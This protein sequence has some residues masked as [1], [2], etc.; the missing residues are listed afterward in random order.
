M[1]DF[2]EY[3]KYQHRHASTTI[4]GTESAVRRFLRWAP[5][6]GV[7]TEDTSHKEIMKYTRYLADAGNNQHSIYSNLNALSHYF[8]YQIFLG[9]G[10]INPIKAIKIQG[11]KRETLYDILSPEEL[12]E[13]YRSYPSETP[14]DTR[15][16]VIIGLYVF[17]GIHTGELNKIEVHHVDLQRLKILIPSSRRSKSRILNLDPEQL[18]D[19]QEYLYKVRDIMLQETQKETLQ[20]IVSMG[21]S[22]NTN[23][24]LDKLM[25]RLEKRC[26]QLTGGAKQIRASVITQW[27]KQYDLRKTQRL[28]GHKF[29]SSTERYEAYTYEGLREDLEVFHPV[30]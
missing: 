23:N 4:K 20:L 29:L 30:G 12:R 18:Y 11:I 22:H 2:S 8:S 26:P 27:L 25:K 17:Q 19:L 15:S 21:S 13:M 24:L 16:R 3:L 10:S 1:L 9:E 7:S 5:A 6:N 28:A 14:I